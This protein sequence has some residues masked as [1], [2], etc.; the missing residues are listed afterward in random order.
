MYVE[1]HKALDAECTAASERF[2]NANSAWGKAFTEYKTADRNLSR[3]DE[4]TRPEREREFIASSDR[5]EGATKELNDSS[6]HRERTW[7]DR[8][9]LEKDYPAFDVAQENGISPSDS[10]APPDTPTPGEQASKFMAQTKGVIDTGLMTGQIIAQ[11][12]TATPQVHEQAT[13]VASIH[14][15]QKEV[16]K[17]TISLSEHETQ[18]YEAHVSASPEEPP[19]EVAEK[20]RAKGRVSEKSKE[21]LD[22]LITTIG[23]ENRMTSASGMKSKQDEG[24]AESEKGNAIYDE[25]VENAPKRPA[26]NAVMPPEESIRYTVSGGDE[27]RAPMSLPDPDNSAAVF[28]VDLKSLPAIP[29]PEH[30]QTPAAAPD[31]PSPSRGMPDPDPPASALAA[32]APANDNTP[33]SPANDNDPNF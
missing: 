20:E 28:A 6:E 4:E 32:K 29:D 8:A 19:T 21:E 7:A 13:P 33:R 25:A 12:A 14:E 16:F 3:A 31:G 10:A 1:R 23:R 2:Q 26:V 17:E 30:Q 15:I 5:L 18:V 9:A 27:F 11:L 22:S 24:I